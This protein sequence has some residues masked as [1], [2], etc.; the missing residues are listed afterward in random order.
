MLKNTKK[1]QAPTERWDWVAAEP[2]AAGSGISRTPAEQD[3]AAQ[4]V[5]PFTPVELRQEWTWPQQV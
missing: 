1:E 2:R 5:I 4:A 3:R